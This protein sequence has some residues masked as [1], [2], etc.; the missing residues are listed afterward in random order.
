MPLTNY[1]PWGL[2]EEQAFL[3]RQAE[4]GRLQENIFQ[5]RHTLLLA[6]RRYGKSSLA[7][8]VIRRMDLPFVSM[9]LF[10]AINPKTVLNR[11]IE[12][13]NDLLAQLSTAP[14]QWLML[15]KNFF[16]NSEQH[17]TFGFKGCQLELRPEKE[18]DLAKIILEGLEAIEQILV[19]KNQHALFFIDEFQEINKLEAGR[20]I[21][22]AIRHYAQKPGHIS[23]IFSGSSRHLLEE[24]FGD[25]ERPLY[26][27]CDWINHP[28]LDASLYQQYLSKVT[29]ETWNEPLD[30]NFFDEI[31]K[32]TECHP[33]YVYTLCAQIW[34]Y[35][36]AY[37]LSV[38]SAR[39]KKIWLDYVVDRSKKVR[40]ELA[41]LSAGQLKLLIWIAQ[42]HNTLMTSKETQK[43]LELTGPTLF[44]AF[45][46]LEEEDYVERLPDQSF[47]IIDPL[48]KSTLIAHYEGSF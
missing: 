22:G 26:E 21:E 1:F 6:P 46:I 23:F 20:E 45:K 37:G 19:K 4:M 30:T 11:F 25:R 9:D 14:E 8:Y 13:L 16:N 42:G 7:N 31:I 48:I 41:H 38:D 12:G 29:Q 17:W 28:R 2:A 43:K 32:F 44:H 33:K 10:L 15:L 35:R 47:R 3:G 27:L 18:T 5:G 34:S 36:K 40:A 39:V 24:L